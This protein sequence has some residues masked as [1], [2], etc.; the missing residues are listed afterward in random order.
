MKKIEISIIIPIYNAEKYLKKT[1]D[2]ICS[3]KYGNYEVLMINDGSTDNS[4]EICLNYAN[5]NEKFKYF[6]KKNSGVS[7]TRNYGIQKSKGNY[8]C[9][10]DADDM[11]DENYLIDF[12]NTLKQYEADIVCCGIK[13]FR[14]ES[15]INKGHVKINC[16]TVFANNNYEKYNTLFSEYG[17]YVWNKIFKKD[18]I[19]K[20]DIRFSK[21]IYMCEDMLFLFQYIKHI[22]KIAYINKKNY[23]YRVL[24]SS[25]SNNFKNEKWFSVFKVYDHFL[26]DIHIFSKQT[27]N[28]ILYS[29][30]FYTLEAKFRI[31]KIKKNQIFNEIKKDN[32][33]RIEY[34][35]KI[36]KK[37]P[38]KQKSK[39]LIY[40]Y[41]PTIAFNLK[42]IKKRIK[43]N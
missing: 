34:Y 43:K 16:E 4:E 7:D 15:K 19:K 11:L 12:I 30:C 3:Q 36:R 35:K 37:L 38:T 20:Y 33:K 6:L 23:Y 14:N 24:N 1:L 41:F 2:S 26:K 39:I 13:K 31:K 8:I 10:A 18:I 40:E 9:F 42:Y 17:G 27:Q 21:D 32:S 25:L 22:N 28:K 29:I 5:N